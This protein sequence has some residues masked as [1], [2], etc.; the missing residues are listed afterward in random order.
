ME[1]I[2]EIT[3]SLTQREQQL[4]KDAIDCGFWGDGDYEFLNDKGEV[5]IDSMYGYCTNDAKNAGNFKGRVI[6]AMFPS[7]YK[8]LCP[9][10]GLGRYISHCS[11]WWGDGSGD[12]LFIRKSYVEAFETWANES[13]Q[14]V[15]NN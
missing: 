13:I 8:K 6:S 12:M 14:S 4:L 10:N 11:D 1:T 7:I 3:Q 5:E 2:N 15:S 9:N